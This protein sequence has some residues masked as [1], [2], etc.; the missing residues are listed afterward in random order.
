MDLRFF[1]WNFEATENYLFMLKRLELKKSN[2][3]LLSDELIIHLTEKVVQRYVEAGTIPKKEKEDV[4]MSVIEKFLQKQNSI[5]N[6]YK[7]DAK[8]STY[9]VAVLSRMTCEV[10]RKE[11]KHWK[12][13]NQDNFDNE[14]YTDTDLEE[15]L[16]IKDETKLLNRILLI[17]DDEFFKIKLFL[18]YFYQLKIDESLI[19]EYDNNCKINNIETYFSQTNL[20]NK[21]DIFKNLAN[22]V[23]IVENKDLKADAIRMWLNKCIN[24]IIFR[25]N[26]PYNRANYDKESLGILFEYY[27]TNVDVEFDKKKEV[28]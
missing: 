24:K 18:A 26:N 2:T 8:I 16:I 4:K 5:N 28:S 15:K 23:N 25:L 14:I 3:N 11:L 13:Q 1:L 20:N 9:Y 12:N 17:F 7:G 27:F 19:K 22:I 21:G 10:I 6:A